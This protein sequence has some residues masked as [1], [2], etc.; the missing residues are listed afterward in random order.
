MGQAERWV[1]N[2]RIAWVSSSGEEVVNIE[3]AVAKYAFGQL[4]QS[5][6]L[7]MRIV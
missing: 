6:T 2:I 3:T 5:F 4:Q 1:K 7:C